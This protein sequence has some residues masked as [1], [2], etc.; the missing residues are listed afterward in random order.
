MM[1]CLRAIRVEGDA[2]YVPLTQGCVSVIDASD[3]PLIAGFN[4]VAHR[5][6]KDGAYYARSRRRDTR[7]TILLHRIILGAPPGLVVDHISGDTLDNRRS[8]SRR[9]TIGNNVFNSRISR[10]NTSGFKGVSWA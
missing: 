5:N 1:R 6:K 7:E 2:A 4:W 3:I 9:A 8:N 10:S